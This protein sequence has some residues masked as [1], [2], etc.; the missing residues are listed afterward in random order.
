M[1]FQEFNTL[2]KLILSKVLVVS[3]VVL[4]PY[5]EK[6]LEI[7]KNIDPDDA[8]FIACALAYPDSIIWS[9]DKDLKKQTK[10]K[11]LNTKEI[12]DLLY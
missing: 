7:V 9:N 1:D 11:V 5:Y 10:I 3:D 2:F 6:A 12:I 8:L 4:E